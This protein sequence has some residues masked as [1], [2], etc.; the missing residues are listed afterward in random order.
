[1][2]KTLE[3]TV[4][5]APSPSGGETAAA[6]NC[7]FVVGRLVALSEDQQPLVTYRNAPTDSALIAATTVDLA[8]EHIGEDVALMFDGSPLKP[9][10]MGRIRRRTGWAGPEQPNVEIDADGR[11]L[12]IS[13]TD[14]IVLR[15][16][17]ASVTLTAAGK[18]L[19]E[20]AYVTTR[21]TGVMRI[22]GGSVQIN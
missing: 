22:K 7:Q 1:M 11:R 5:D 15:C 18:V 16:G 9:I 2:S 10:V 17:K 14:T 3:S 4:M 8:P 20:G 12:T 6:T 21:S 19:I 13:A